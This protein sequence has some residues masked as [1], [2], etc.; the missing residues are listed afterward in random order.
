[1]RTLQQN[2]QKLF[3]SLLIGEQPVYALDDE[4]NKIIEY[5]DDEGNIYYQEIEEQLRNMQISN[6]IEYFNDEYMPSFY[7]DRLEMAHERT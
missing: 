5:I 3:Y 1:M 7:Y 6:P 2:K 4:G